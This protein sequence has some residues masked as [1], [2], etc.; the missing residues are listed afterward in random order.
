MLLAALRRFIVLLG[1]TA[2]GTAA[3]SIAFGSLLGAS[4]TRSASLGEYLVGSFLLLT[5]FVIGNRGPVR[6]KGDGFG[7]FIG[8]HVV[9]WATATEQEDSINSS[10]L[11]VTLGIGLIVLGVVADTRYRLF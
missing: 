10:A 8:A 7:G 9:R 11:F 5:G 6:S 3:I 1:L 2:V 4:V